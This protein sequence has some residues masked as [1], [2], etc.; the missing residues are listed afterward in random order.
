MRIVVR[1]DSLRTI[2]KWAQRVLCVAGV[3]MV[4][5]CG[6]VLTQTWIFQEEERGRFEKLLTDRQNGN[7]GVRAPGLPHSTDD[8]P[9]AAAGG[10]IG[11]IEIPRLGVSSMVIEGTSTTT[12]RRAVG[13]I[14]GT[15]MP[16]QPGNVG[17]SGHRDTFFRPLRNIQQ[18]DI[19]T[20]TTLLGEYR[21][22]VVLTKVVDPQDVEVLNSS[23]SEILTLVTCYPFF[24]V[25]PAPRRFI[26]R[27]ERISDLTVTTSGTV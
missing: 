1:K 26:V 20:L 10:L 21:Y 15:S 19:V 5:Y 6:F 14:S 25:G 7:G 22:R 12:L 4:A 3:S 23:G 11:H 17:L 13:H 2:L 16:G 24:F 18:N 8:S 9:L 27:A